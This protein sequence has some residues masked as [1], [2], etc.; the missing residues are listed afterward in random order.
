[1]TTCSAPVSEQMLLDYWVNDLPDEAERDRIETHLFECGDCSARLE[2]LAAL[3]PA[4]A[5]LLREGR[6]AGIISRTI[7]NRLQR[8][9]AHVRMFSL[10]PGETVPC[11]IFP[12]DDLVVTALRADFS[13]IDGLTLSVTK[14]GGSLFAQFEDVPAP[15][16][17]GE[18]LWATPASVVKEMP[19]MR[20][21][22]SLVSTG[23]TRAEIG[24]YVLEHQSST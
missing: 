3:G 8:E 10:V 9:G 16:A 22:I 7:L 23:A 15:G 6:I 11:A 1:M 19:S 4:L 13:G 14:A 5:T 12:G 21:E 20:L 17:R 2:Q 24:R 18:V